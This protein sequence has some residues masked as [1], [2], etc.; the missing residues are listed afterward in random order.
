MLK[1]KASAE[2][3]DGKTRKKSS[4]ILRDGELPWKNYEVVCRG[5]FPA[6]AYCFCL[7]LFHVGP[8]KSLCGEG[9][10]GGPMMSKIV[11]RGSGR[12]GKTLQLRTAKPVSPK[13]PETVGKVCKCGGGGELLSLT[14]YGN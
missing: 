8:P 3:E 5:E 7:N 12:K 1:A 9:R 10:R 6:S 4:E 13:P 11:A 14:S 2:A